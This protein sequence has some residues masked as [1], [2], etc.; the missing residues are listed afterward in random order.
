MKYNNT[1]VPPLVAPLSALSELFLLVLVEVVAEAVAEKEEENVEN[2]INTININTFY[3]YTNTS[4]I[5]NLTITKFN[6][7]LFESFST[8]AFSI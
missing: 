6:I 2:I 4:I 5:N 8:S 7:I 1:T 3:T